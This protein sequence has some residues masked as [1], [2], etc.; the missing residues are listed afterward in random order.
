MQAIQ[1][2]CD[3]QSEHQTMRGSAAHSGSIHRP[4]FKAT[5]AYRLDSHHTLGFERQDVSSQDNVSLAPAQPSTCGLN[6]VVRAQP[7]KSHQCSGVAFMLTS[8]PVQCCIICQGLL[9]IASSDVASYSV[10]R[11]SVRRLQPQ[12]PAYPVPSVAVSC[13]ILC[14]PISVIHFQREGAGRFRS[15]F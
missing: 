4:C 5:I 6:H 7:Q 13:C 8:L 9:Y 1:G 12:W 11:P 10:C 15:T 3:H 2:I 14:V